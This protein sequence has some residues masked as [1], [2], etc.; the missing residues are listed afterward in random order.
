MCP[1]LSAVLSSLVLQALEVTTISCKQNF[2]CAFFNVKERCGTRRNGK[3]FLLLRG[4]FGSAGCGRTAKV[5]VD[6]GSALFLFS[7]E[8]TIMVLYLTDIR[9]RD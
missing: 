8:V 4:D 3:A 6:R 5:S 9:G 2:S 7:A 1:F